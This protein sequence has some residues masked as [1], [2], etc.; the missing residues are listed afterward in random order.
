MGKLKGGILGPVTGL[1]GA[2][3]GSVMGGQNIVKKRPSCYNDLGSQSQLDQRS[4]FANCLIWYKVLASSA[5]LGFKERLAI[6]SAYNA[7]MAENIGTG[8][9]TSTPAWGALKVAKG[10]LI[11]PNFS[12]ATTA[13]D[14]TLKFDW[15][16]DS[17]GS[18]KLATDKVVAV[19]IEPISK[20][21]HISNGA[22][23]RA[24]ETLTVTIPA[25]FEG[26]D[27]QTYCFVIR[28]DGKK[29][30]NSLRTGHGIAGSDLAGSVQ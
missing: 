20:A 5:V 14:S 17:D 24:D 15:E 10:S 27:V 18:V 19:I 8:V 2:V 7:F 4:A 9:I 3:V 6:H 26:L 28:A 21:V 23:T 12:M 22:K 30:S 29:A 13:V 16:D 1:V 25:A 11:N